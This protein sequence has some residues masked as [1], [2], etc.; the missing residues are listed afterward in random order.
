LEGNY[1]RKKNVD[2]VFGGHPKGKT[3]RYHTD[4]GSEFFQSD[5][6]SDVHPVTH[7]PMPG[8]DT[9]AQYGNINVFHHDI[10]KDVYEGTRHMHQRLHH[11]VIENAS[12]Q[13]GEDAAK[14]EENITVSEQYHLYKNIDNAL[15]LTILIDF[16]GSLEEWAGAPPRWPPQ[17]QGVK[18][19]NLL[20]LFR[21]YYTASRHAPMT[22]KC[23]CQSLRKQRRFIPLKVEVLSSYNTTPHTVGWKTE[24][25]MDT[26]YTGSPGANRVMYVS[27]PD[28]GRQKQAMPFEVDMTNFLDLDDVEDLRFLGRDHYDDTINLKQN[29]D[30]GSIVEDSNVYRVINEIFSQ[31]IVNEYND[32][33]VN[34]LFVD[35]STKTR[36][37]DSAGVWVHN[38]PRRSILKAIQYLD[39]MQERLN[40]SSTIPLEG[41]SIV[42][43]V[44]NDKES[45]EALEN[46][47]QRELK[48]DKE[49][50]REF[51]QDHQSLSIVLKLYGYW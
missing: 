28:G 41:F 49:R 37:E 24:T 16:H 25:I 18:S 51:K 42:P 1:P 12:S 9:A 7:D 40:S 36:I 4:D 38:I 15:C 39:A 6:Y 22:T 46:T 47:S 13:H 50:L 2:L 20:E 27:Y 35:F 14:Y 32:E 8:K 43:I 17:G 11:S 44:L 45:W 31:K 34:P 19:V 26:I 21:K 30:T 23:I 10:Q 33:I 48:E 5:A 29:S 3:K